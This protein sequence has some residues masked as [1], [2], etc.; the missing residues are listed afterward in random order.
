MAR[1]PRIEA[2]V[3]VPESPGGIAAEKSLMAPSA[4]LWK[5]RAG[6]ERLAYVLL[7]PA[8]LLLVALIAYPF[9]TSLYM[10]LTDRRIAMPGRFVGLR[11]FSE[12]LLED[13]IFQQTLWNSGL[14]VVGAVGLKT[15]TG[16]A[17]AL[18]LHGMT[19][20]RPVFQALLMLPWVVPASLSV[21][22]WWWMFDPMS[23]VINWVLVNVG[24]VSRP[25]RWLSDPFWARSA[26]IITNVW[27]GLPFFALCFLAG[28]VSIPREL[29]EAA[30]SDGAGPMASFWHIT[31]PLLR[32]MLGIVILYS[33][34][35]T[36]ADFEIVFLLT[37][38]GPRN[39]TH[40]LGTLAYHVGLS[41]GRLGEAAAIS[42]FI[43]PVL[44]VVAYFMLRAVRHGTEVA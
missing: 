7:A 41:G 11:N 21:L 4:S 22:A 12:L 15:V 30:E 36:I 5:P 14:Y 9:V 39:S 31:L 32:P 40:L 13:E 35:M 8:V 10:S 24:I 29:Y 3:T 25:I 28:L 2:D 17:A 23:S 43:F 6:E 44:A 42:L 27:R 37:R 16:L 26:I 1:M 18:L 38:G 33:V 34:V 20:G 19:R